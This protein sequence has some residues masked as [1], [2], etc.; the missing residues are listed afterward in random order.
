MHDEQPQQAVS[1]PT[2]GNGDTQVI[3]KDASDKYVADP[4]GT[5]AET[6]PKLPDMPRWQKW[7]LWIGVALIAY[8]NG[9]NLFCLAVY[10][11]TAAAQFNG[12]VQYTTLAVIQSMLLAAGKPPFA[13]LADI[14]GRAVTYAVSIL[15]FTVGTIVIAS[16]QGIGGLAAGMVIFALGDC[17][18]TLCQQ[19]VLADLISPRWRCTYSNLLAFHFIINFAIASKITGS[20]VPENWRWG[21]GMFTIMMPVVALPVIV[22]LAMQQREAIKRGIIYKYPYE[23]MSHWQGLKAFALD[24]DLAGLFCFSGGF[25]L[26]LLPLTIADRAP[27]G[28]SS[29]YIIAMFVLGGCLLIAW[30]FVE[31]YAPRPLVRIRSFFTNPD[32]IA[33]AAINFVDQFSYTMTYTPAFQWVEVVYDWNTSDATYF[34][35]TQSLCLVVFAIAAGF[36]ASMTRRYK[37]V[38]FSGSCIRL[39]GLGLMIKYRGAHSSAFQVVMPQ[40]IQGLGGGLMTANLLV[41]AQ[42]SVPHDEVA[43]VTGFMLLVI[44]LGSAIGASVVGAVQQNLKGQLH[45]YID[46]VVNGNSTVAELIYAQA[47]SGL[48]EYPL[49]SPVRTATINAWTDNM[50]QILIASITI[51]AVNILTCLGLP[52][53]V[54]SD[55]QN[56]V[57]DEPVSILPPT[58]ALPRR[59]LP[60]TTA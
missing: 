32:I 17:G 18:I 59:P 58:A 3:N 46:P 11:N 30:P 40:V 29:G 2:G 4:N 26:L 35:Y 6:L 28:Y 20:L 51:A 38:A 25:L 27:H 15:F 1:A 5:G 21:V 7:I 8:V 41:S 44:E 48:A 24:I 22:V 45:H 13:K 37:W 56:N 50:H 49:G 14:I 36:A 39:L 54:L 33:P 31:T 42:A 9:L 23:N 55:K 57:T 12:I 43:I 53:R 16:S 60:T 52:D 10:L 47:A 19:L 34:Y